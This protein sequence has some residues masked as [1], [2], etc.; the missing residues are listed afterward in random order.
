MATIKDIAAYCNVAV[1]TVSR[2]LN[3]H[4]DVSAETRRKVLDAVHSLHY[5]PNN[6]ARDLVLPQSDSIGLV[7]RGAENPF[8]TPI[9]RAVEKACEDR[10]YTMVLHQIPADGDEVGEGARLVQSKRL[11]GLIMLGGRYDYT[12]DD[13]SAIGVPFVCCT[14]TNHF[15][16]LDAGSFSSVSIDDKAEAYRA[17]KQ[18][19]DNG[20]TKIAI[21]LDSKTDRSISERRFCGYC[22][23]LADAGISLDEGLACETVEF[24]MGAAFACVERFIAERPDITAIFSV[25][26]TMAIAAMKAIANSGRIIPDDISI[27]SIDGIEMSL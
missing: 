26:D 16:D 6:A 21:L 19:I 4:P 12:S 3:D 1:S 9:I 17:V 25:A 5:V 11:R 18:L 7:V 10:G 24:N 22:E 27:I 8:F 15:G 2:A 14:Y 23:A 20:H 13:V